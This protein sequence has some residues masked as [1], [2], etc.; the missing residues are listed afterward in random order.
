M[1]NDVARRAVPPLMEGMLALALVLGSARVA[2]AAPVVGFVEEFASAGQV[3]GWIGQ[4][5]ITN[6]GTGGVGGA[7]DGY[8]S[9]STRSVAGHLGSASFDAAYSGDWSTAGITLLKVYLNDTGIQDP[10]E[11]HFSIGNMTNFWQYNIGFTP[12]HQQWAVYYVNLTS[13]ANWTQIRGTGS[14]ESALASADRIHFRHDLAPFIQSPN[15][16]QGEFGIDRVSLTA[17]SVDVLPVSW[18]RLKALYR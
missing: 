12:P 1:P 15:N 5:Q 11:I 4:P 14:F 3:G 2:L 10:L 7:A 17:E 8:L 18:G 9:V 13:S 6:P 16:I